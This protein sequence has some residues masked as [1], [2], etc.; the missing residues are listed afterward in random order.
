MA[1]LSLLFGCATA[2]MAVCSFVKTENQKKLVG[3][4]DR[5]PPWLNDLSNS[6]KQA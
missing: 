5:T 2:L 3:P 6:L 1:V 4:T